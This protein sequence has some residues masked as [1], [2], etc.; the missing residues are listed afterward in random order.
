MQTVKLTEENPVQEVVF[1][2]F[3]EKDEDKFSLLIIE[4]DYTPGMKLNPGWYCIEAQEEEYGEYK[5]Q[6]MNLPLLT[7]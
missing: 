3:K 7:I 5:A 1:E 6:V 4:S 2:Y